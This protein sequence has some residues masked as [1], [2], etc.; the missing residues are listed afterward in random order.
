MY[1]KGSSIELI[2]L[3]FRHF[4]D[5]ALTILEFYEAGERKKE[6]RFTTNRDELSRIRQ[7]CIEYT[8][9]ANDLKDVMNN[10][11]LISEFNTAHAFSNQFKK[12]RLLFFTKIFKRLDI[13]FQRINRHKA[14]LNIVVELYFKILLKISKKTN[15]LIGYLESDRWHND[16]AIDMLLKLTQL[17][18]DFLCVFERFC[19]LLEKEKKIDLKKKDFSLST[20]TSVN[21]SSISTADMI[22]NLSK[23]TC[24]INKLSSLIC[25]L[26]KL[27]DFYLYHRNNRTKCFCFF[28]FLIFLFMFLFFIVLFSTFKYLLL[29]KIETDSEFYTINLSDQNTK[30]LVDLN[31]S[32]NKSL[33]KDSVDSD[34]FRNINFRSII[35]S[36]SNVLNPVKGINDEKKLNGSELNDIFNYMKDFY[37]FAA[38]LTAFISFEWILNR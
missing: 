17:S 32:I 31:E 12:K 8:R 11:D 25:P 38:S 10:K 16:A 13:L 23:N 34:F 2:I 18:N 29:S 36:D 26:V 9:L 33:K 21:T 35:F 15:E 22:K 7:Y 27:S 19:E 1:A 5:E 30:S 20:T 37:V 4:I 24:V 3:D 6:K 14:L 28:C